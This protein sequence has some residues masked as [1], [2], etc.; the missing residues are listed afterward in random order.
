MMSSAATTGGAGGARLGSEEEVEVEVGVG[1]IIRSS[2]TGVESSDW[3]ITWEKRGE[4]V[5]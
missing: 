4:N 1:E 2:I 5:I 3:L